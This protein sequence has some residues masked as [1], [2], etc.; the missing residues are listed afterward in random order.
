MG[1]KQLIQKEAGVVPWEIP[2]KGPMSPGG[3]PGIEGILQNGLPVVH[4]NL[5]NPVGIQAL[6]LTGIRGGDITRTIHEMN[7]KRQ[8]LLL[9]MVRS[10]LVKKLRLGFLG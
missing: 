8:G 3:I 4:L 5:K 7:S 6:H 2:V 1:I 10:R 9:L